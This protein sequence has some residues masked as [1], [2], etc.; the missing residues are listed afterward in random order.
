MKIRLGPKAE[1]NGPITAAAHTPDLPDGRRY[2]GDKRKQRSVCFA[3]G[4]VLFFALKSEDQHAG[5]G[6]KKAPLLVPLCFS[7]GQ[8][9]VPDTQRTEG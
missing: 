2:R 4:F 9:F 7:G 6:V 5:R 8:R 3:F 1:H